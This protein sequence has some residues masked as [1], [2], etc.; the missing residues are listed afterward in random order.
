MA[1]AAAVRSGARRVFVPVALRGNAAL[2]FSVAAALVF[3]GL[4]GILASRHEMWRDELQAWLLARDSSSPAALLYNMRYEGHPGLWHLMLWPVARFTWNPAGM[5]AVH[6]LIAGCSAFLLF[7]FAPFPVL[8]RLLAACG[9][10]FAY[11]W[12]VIA[13]NYAVSVPLL[14]SVC[15]LFKDR[16]RNFVYIASLLFLLCH[17]NVHSI[18]LAGVLT[19]FLLVEFAVA[20]AAKARKAELCLGRVAAGLFIILLGLYT[21]IAQTAPPPD[22]G[23]ATRWDYGWTGDRRNSAAEKIVSAFLAVPVNDARFWNRNRFLEQSAGE[24]GPKPAP[25]AGDKRMRYGMLILFGLAVPF[26]KRPW[27][28]L[29]YLCASF[30]LLAFFYIKY[31]GGPR[32]HGFLYL[33]FFAALWMSHHCTPWRFPWPPLEAVLAFVDRRRV[34]LFVP[35]FAV[36]AWGAGTAIGRDWKETFSTAR[37]TAQWLDAE[38]PDRSTVFFAGKYGPSSSAVAAY[39]RLDRMYYLERGEFGSYIIWDGNRGRNISDSL[40][41]EIPRVMEQT[42]KKAVIISDG[43]LR[44]PGG[45]PLRL[46]KSFGGAVEVS[47]NNC[48]YIMED[49][50]R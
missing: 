27:Q 41:R 28:G 43:P 25:I 11:E 2:V 22:S 20:Y 46:L 30:A 36:Q 10:F 8:I 42:G 18:I 40:A 24:K 31:P 6:V 15:A 35:L 17:T 21:G 50:D 44:A 5:Q 23:F 38:F 34:W 29:F 1:D 47:E 13:R 48:V 7:R 37:D 9:Y 49:P 45:K 12:A 3:T 4:V 26:F 14:F 19:F 16:W 32:H 33:A 39:L